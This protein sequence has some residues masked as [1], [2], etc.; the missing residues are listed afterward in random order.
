MTEPDSPDMVPLLM[1]LF[2]V[3][4]AFAVVLYRAGAL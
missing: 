3:L 4:F 1:L 2:V